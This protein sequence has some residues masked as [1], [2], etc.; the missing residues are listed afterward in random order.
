MDQSSLRFPS[1]HSI[2]DTIRSA[3][4]SRQNPTIESDAII[5]A[6]KAQV[7]EAQVERRDDKLFEG[8]WHSIRMDNLDDRSAL[9]TYDLVVALH[10]EAILLTMALYP[11]LAILDKDPTLLS[12]AEVF[13]LPTSHTVSPSLTLHWQALGWAQVWWFQSYAVQLAAGFSGP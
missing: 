3:L 5:E 13:V 6:F 11:S 8:L 7:L 9:T 2:C 4:S 12:I 1:W 10:C